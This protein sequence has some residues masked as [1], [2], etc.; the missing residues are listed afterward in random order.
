MCILQDFEG[1]T[2][3]IMARTIETVEGG[4]L[5][6][7]LLKSMTSLKQLY[8]MTMD[9][10]S[11]YRTEAHDDVVA[12]FNERFLLSLSD[13]ANC[14]VLDDEL[15]V[16][17]VSGGRN[18]KRLPPKD[19][20]EITPNEKELI[21]L[22]DNLSDVQPAGS[23]ISLAK[24]VNQAEAIL[25]FIDAITEKTLN[26]TVSLTAGRGRGKSAALE[27]ENFFPIYLKR[28]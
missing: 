22:K 19:E 5:V 6:V 11:R 27:F 4:G 9:V 25:R 14:L 2:P 3:N 26:T 24:T 7:I 13:C 12:R 23:L 15:N 8:T 17:P 20:D 1:L 21:Q 16:L 18:V 10:H 28:I